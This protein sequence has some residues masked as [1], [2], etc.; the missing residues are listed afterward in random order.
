MY[1][2]FKKNKFNVYYSDGRIAK[3]GFKYEDE[4]YEWLEIH[5]SRDC[6]YA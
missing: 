2:E 6:Q 5:L 1:I 4:A 3:K